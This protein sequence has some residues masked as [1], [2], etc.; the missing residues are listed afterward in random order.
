MDILVRAVKQ[1]TNVSGK[2]KTLF[3]LRIPE[4]KRKEYQ[5]IHHYQTLKSSDIRTDIG[6]S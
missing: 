1:I 6:K 2:K 5:P 3:T 4:E